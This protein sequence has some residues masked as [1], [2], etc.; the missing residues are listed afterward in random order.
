MNMLQVL[1]F[2][3]LWSFIGSSL[4]SLFV[5]FVFR[6]GAVYA[7]RRMDGTLK[8]EIPLRGY[9]AMAA[10]LLAILGF[11]VLSNYFGFVMS[12][13]RLNFGSIYL[14]NLALYLILF[15]FDTVVIDGLVLARW[16]PGFLRLS[17]E[18]GRDSMKEH[19]RKSIPIGLAFG[20]FL[21]AVS[22]ALTSFLWAD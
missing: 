21:A 5:I 22:A 9:L 8:E 1:R 13:L 11:F 7:S 6:S 19:I 3:A 20:I 14:L 2:L 4:F 17:N 18:I 12:S 15:L 10:F 16:R